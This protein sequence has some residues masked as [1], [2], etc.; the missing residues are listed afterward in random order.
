MMAIGQAPSFNNNGFDSPTASRA[1]RAASKLRNL[2]LPQ[3]F[4]SH[5]QRRR[6]QTTKPMPWLPVTSSMPEYISANA[7]T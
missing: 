6:P 4:H 7:P 3:Q 1:Q 5:Q 2:A